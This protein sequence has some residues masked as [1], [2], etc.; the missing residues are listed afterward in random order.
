MKTRELKRIV[1]KMF[2]DREFYG[3]EVHK[4]L[5]SEDVKIEISRLYRVL[6]EMLREGL[7]EG[8]WEKS[9]LGPRKRVYG[10]GGKGREEL[11]KIVLDAINTV[12]MFYGKYLKSLAPKV[13]V[14]HNICA[15]L[16]AGLKEQS[17]IAYVTLQYSPMHERMIRTIHNIVPQGKIYLIKPDSVQVDLKLDNLTFLDGSYSNVSLRKDFLDL[18]VV[19]DLPPKNYLATA[20]KEWRRVLKQDGRLAILSPTVLINKYEDPLTIGDF[21]EK[22]EHITIKKDEPIDKEFLQTL[23]RSS[24]NMVEEIQIVHMTILLGSARITR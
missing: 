20:L 6:N 13:N 2:G 7:L 17:N 10:I 22:Y 3:Y 19:I 1:L 4:K 12:H 5:V 9:P 21:I 14:L 11:Y 8:R 18:L 16:T 23:L 24:F 15:P